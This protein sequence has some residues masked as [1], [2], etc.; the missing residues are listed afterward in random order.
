MYDVNVISSI[1]QELGNC[2]IEDLY[3]ILEKIRPEIIF[4]E[5]NYPRFLE[6]YK[7]QKPFSLETHTITKYMQNNK[8]EHIP[9]DTYDMPEIDD[10]KKRYLEKYIHE[11]DNE[12][13]KILYRQTQL[14]GLYGFSALNSIQFN[15]LMEMI[16]R[17]EEIF[18]NN[19]DNEEYKK[20]YKAWIEFTNNREYEMIRNI[21]NYSKKNKYNNAIF[22]IGADH[23]NPIQ[24]KIHEYKEEQIHIN[25]IFDIKNLS[26]MS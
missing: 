12:Y 16:K 14:A 25:W 20:T 7:E 26:T 2:D 11:N 9:V 24:K 6:A 4:E 17:Q 19:T 18:Y 3:K 22:L 13:R 8:I 10:D 15:D 23:I 1:H 5:L 21:Y